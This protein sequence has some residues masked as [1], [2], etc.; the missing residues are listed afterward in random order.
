M[1][2]LLAESFDRIIQVDY[3]R[4]MEER[5]DRIEEG[6]ADYEGTLG[7]FYKAFQVDLA[8]AASRCLTSRPKDSRATRP[9][10]SVSR[11]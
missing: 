4:E 3:T 10:T 2:D 11:R 9:A 5:L 1:T 8:K 7:T 6:E